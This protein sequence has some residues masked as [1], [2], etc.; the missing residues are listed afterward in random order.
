MTSIS[1]NY[2]KSCGTSSRRFA[3]IEQLDVPKNNFS[4]C[5]RYPPRLDLEEEIY[6]Q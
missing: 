2:F 1:K 3:S 4:P 6:M 5:H